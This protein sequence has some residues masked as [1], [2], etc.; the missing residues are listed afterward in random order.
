MMTSIP[1]GCNNSATI[2]VAFL[3]ERLRRPQLEMFNEYS[4]ARTGIVRIV[5]LQH[6]LSEAEWKVG[7]L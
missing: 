6:K 4:M 5:G 3:P 2:A 1:V 7:L